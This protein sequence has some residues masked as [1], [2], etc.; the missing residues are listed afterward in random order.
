VARVS[1][2]AVAQSLVE[3]QSGRIWVE[4]TLGEG[5][6][7]S[8]HVTADVS[9]CDTNS[10]ICPMAFFVSAKNQII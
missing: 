5:T 2:L 7:F 9:L 6:V 4:S 10:A 8:V 3:A 1:A